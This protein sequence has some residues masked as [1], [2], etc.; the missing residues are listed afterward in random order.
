MTQNVMEL[1]IVQSSKLQALATQTSHISDETSTQWKHSELST[2]SLI[3]STQHREKFCGA[4]C[5]NCQWPV[6][7][8]KPCCPVCYCTQIT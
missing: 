2:R 1:C 6:N 4:L 8:E 5:R 3:H 7:A